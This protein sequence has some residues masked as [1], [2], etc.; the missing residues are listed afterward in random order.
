[1]V[2]NL[3]AMQEIQ[4]WSLG[5]EDPLEK[6]MATHSS[7]PAWRIP[8]LFPEFHSLKTL[9]NNREKVFPMSQHVMIRLSSWGKGLMFGGQSEMLSDFYL[10]WSDED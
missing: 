9:W 3:P 4:V 1:M 5:R 10:T 6:K 7:I 2:T 8:F